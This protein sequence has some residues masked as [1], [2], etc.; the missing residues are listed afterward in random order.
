V[1]F[2]TLPDEIAMVGVVMIVTAGLYVL[3]RE[4]KVRNRTTPPKSTH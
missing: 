1:V 3:H 4:R 2:G